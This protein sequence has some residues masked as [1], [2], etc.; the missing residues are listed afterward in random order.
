MV[1][2][3][4]NG[5]MRPILTW[6]ELDEELPD[7][8]GGKWLIGNRKSRASEICNTNVRAFD[9]RVDSILKLR[10]GNTVVQAGNPCGVERLKRA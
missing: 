8:I 7:D 10:F 2:I 1:E 4:R 5:T 3:N 9:V 6:I